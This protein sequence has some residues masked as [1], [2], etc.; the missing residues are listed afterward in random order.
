MGM[1]DTVYYACP[2]CG[3]RVEQ[4]SKGGGCILDKLHLDDASI[5]VLSGI[6]TEYTCGHCGKRH[7]ILLKTFA[8]VSAL[9]S[10]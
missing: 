7:A 6:G 3:E 2:S 8:S 5:D 4:K 9:D 1:Y 10:K